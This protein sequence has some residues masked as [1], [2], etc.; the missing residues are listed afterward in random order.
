MKYKSILIGFINKKQNKKKC[1]ENLKELKTL[2]KNLKNIII[3]KKFIQRIRKINSKTYIGKGKI[4]EIKK[5]IIKN[6]IN[7]IIFDDKISSIQYKNIE[8]YMNYNIKIIDRT[9]IIL[10][11]FKKRSR[12]YN[13]IIQIKL[14]ENKYLLTKLNK[15][16]SHLK[17]QK[18][19]INFKGP[20][21][22]ELESDKRLIKNKI[23]ILKK[24]TKKI[25][26]QINTQTKNRKYINQISIIGY[27]NS[28]KSTIS[29]LILK[30][31]F[32][33][34][35]NKVFSTINTKTKKA[36]INNKIILITDTVG[37]IKKLPKELLNS[38]NTTLYSIIKSNI[39]LS[40]LDLSSLFIED[41]II[42]IYN[43]YKK[44]KINN[45]KIINI[46]N[47]TDINIYNKK[48]IK[49]L[50]IKYNIKNYIFFNYK[51]NINIIINKI[52]NILKFL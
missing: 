12:N 4:Y 33:I 47:K 19:G 44:Y 39:I 38:F 32:N 31:N 25:N 10:K 6:N 1:I 43:I 2:I 41:Y 23:Y 40:I 36:Y 7:F 3:I 28:G 8:K 16:W 5:F 51:L 52:T 14:A 45:N 29:N 50:I 24:K 26:T 18:G 21:E 35:N 22:K 49:S 37:F 13:S 30:K 20:G 34:I 17:R 48:K 27:T 15:M 46:F 9:Q 42:Y 11:I